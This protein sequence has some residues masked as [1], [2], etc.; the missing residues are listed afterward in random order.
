MLQRRMAKSG[1]QPEGTG[2]IFRAAVLLVVHLQSAN[3]SPRVLLREKSAAV[4][5]VFEAGTDPNHHNKAIHHER[6][7][8]QGF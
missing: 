4:A 7:A 1:A 6:Y 8:F 3:F 5:V 2:Q